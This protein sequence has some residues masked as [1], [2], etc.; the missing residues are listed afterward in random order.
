MTASTPKPFLPLIGVGLI[1]VLACGLYLPFLDN[2]PVFDSGKEGQCNF[3][4]IVQRQSE[5]VRS[6]LA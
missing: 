3:S 6:C 1:M 4:G 5:L 2:L